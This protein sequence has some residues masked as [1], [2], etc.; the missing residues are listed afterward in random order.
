MEDA[1]AQ[2]CRDITVKVISRLRHDVARK[3]LANE[4]VY[5]R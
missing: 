1:H 2:M 4:T 5:V 3:V